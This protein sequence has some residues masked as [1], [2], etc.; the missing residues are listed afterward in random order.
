[1]AFTELKTQPKVNCVSSET[2][3]RK[4]LLHFLYMELLKA[5]QS[6][7]QKH[8]TTVSQRSRTEKHVVHIQIQNVLSNAMYV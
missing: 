3:I 5:Q 4:I 6:H 8:P 2:L 7:K 1:M